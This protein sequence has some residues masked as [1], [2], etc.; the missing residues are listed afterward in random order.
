MLNH[1]RMCF[2]SQ[3]MDKTGYG[4]G[5]AVNYYPP[6]KSEGY[7]FGVVCASVRLSV[8]PSI[9]SVRPFRPS[10][11]PHFLSVRNH[12][13]VP[14]GQILFILGTNDKYHELSVSYK[15]GQN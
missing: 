2:T 10:V 12:I 3:V 6:T 8:R 14:I 1:Q 11:C 4:S 7:S 15:F 5:A 13:S 9:P